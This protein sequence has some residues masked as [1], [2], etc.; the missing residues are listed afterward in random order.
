MSKIRLSALRKFAALQ[1]I[2]Y[3]RL[4]ESFTTRGPDCGF[5]PRPVA[6]PRMTP[7]SKLPAMQ[8]RSG[9]VILFD[10]C[11]DFAQKEV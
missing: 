1:N 3:M 8:I 7:R 6:E 9:Y 10:S 5:H 4:N 2:A 11:A